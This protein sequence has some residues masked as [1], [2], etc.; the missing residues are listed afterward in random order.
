M[1]MMMMKLKNTSINKFDKAP[2]IGRG[3]LQRGARR[4]CGAAPRGG[5]ARCS[6]PESEAPLRGWAA[7]PRSVEDGRGAKGLQ[8]KGSRWSHGAR[9]ERVWA[10][11]QLRSPALGGCRAYSPQERRTATGTSIAAHAALNSEPVWHIY[12]SW[13]RHIFLPSGIFYVLS[14]PKC[15]TSDGGAISS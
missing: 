5:A 7:G 15:H 13:D 6:V 1:K 4:T 11:R 14:D 10:W 8:Q 12:F 3:Q 9:I 2:R